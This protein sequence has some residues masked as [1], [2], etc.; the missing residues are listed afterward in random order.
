[1]TFIDILYGIGIFQGAS[2]LFVLLSLKNTKQ[3]TNLIMS[4]LILVLMLILAHSWLIR[5]DYFLTSPTLSLAHMP[6]D[7]L[8]GPLLYFYGLSITQEK[9]NKVQMLHFLPAAVAVFPMI[10]FNT[11]TI[12]EQIDLLKFIWYKELNIADINTA[13]LFWPSA[14]DLWLKNALQGTIY[15]TH[16]GIYCLLLFFVIKYS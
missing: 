4:T 14:W 8:I 10:I 11:V 13:H 15:M 6:L 1:M 3:S 7:Y 16:L 5:L 9:F 2:L 12:A